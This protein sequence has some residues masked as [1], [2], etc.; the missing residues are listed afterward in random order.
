[1]DSEKLIEKKFSNTIDNLYK[2]WLTNFLKDIT[3]EKSNMTIFAKSTYL[4]S[5][6]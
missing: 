5:K 1:M 3:G 4:F 6:V 2:I